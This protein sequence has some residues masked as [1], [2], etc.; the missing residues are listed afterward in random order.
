MSAIR[1]CRK[2]HG[3]IV[4]PAYPGDGAWPVG[5]MCRCPENQPNP[6]TEPEDREP[7]PA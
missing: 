1:E 3:N 5:M 7:Q 4:R 6:G 2:C